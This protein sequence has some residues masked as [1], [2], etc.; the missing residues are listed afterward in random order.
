L[1]RFVVDLSYSDIP[2]EVLDLAK[3]FTLE[4]LGHMVLGTAQPISRIVLDYIRSLEAAP[5]AVVVG[6][7]M[8]T[9]VAEAAYANGTFAHA[10]EM[11]SYGTLPGTCT[12]PPIAAALAIGEWK[13]ASG[14]DFLAAFVAGIE[15]QG[16]LGTAGIGACDRGFMGIS[17]VGPAGAGASAGKLIGLSAEGMQNCLG[18]ALPMS[19]GSLRGCGYMT[20]VHE[21][22]VPARTGVWAAQLVDRGFTGSPDYLDGAFSWGEQ[23]VGDSDRPYDHEALT[24][25]LGEQFFLQS[26]GTAPKKYGA[27]G[28]THQTIEGA[29]DLMVHH[30]LRPEDIDHFELRIRPFLDRVARFRDPVDGEQAKFSLVQGIA[31]LLVEGVPLMP[32]VSAFTD[33]AAKDKRYAAARR[34]VH[35]V[36]ET[37]RPSVRGF[38]A[39]TVTIRLSNGKEFSKTVEAKDVRGRTANPLGLDERVEMFRNTVSSL[40]S[41]RVDRIVDVVLNLERHRVR[42]MTALVDLPA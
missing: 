3:I 20:H 27:C 18:V 12:I 22:G 16:R 30:D 29:I 1:S 2:A 6:A 15:M 28:L 35:L 10:D 41:S 31:G 7:G 4:C 34:R 21:A 5:Q 42:E 40:E 8:R 24:A 33:T 13:D 17:L 23:F 39:Q 36:V 25:G 38:D 19:A 14:E 32:Y 11:E 37:D 9:S 26:A